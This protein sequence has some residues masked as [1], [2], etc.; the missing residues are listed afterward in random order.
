MIKILSYNA[1]G[2]I[3]PSFLDII[4]GVSKT[5]DVEKKFVKGIHN[6]SEIVLV[7][8]DNKRS[9]LARKGFKELLKC[10]GCGNCLLHCPMYNTIGNEYAIDSYLGGKGLAYYSLYTDEPHEKLELC[11]RCG[12]CRENCPLELDIPEIIKNLRSTGV[13]SEF[14]YFLKSHMVWVYYQSLLRLEAEKK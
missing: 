14:Y 12:K 4:S 11:L 13:S 5:A 10:I 9:D 6:P 7:L 1:T 2:S 3:I 8:V